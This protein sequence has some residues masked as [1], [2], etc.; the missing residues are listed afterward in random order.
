MIKTISTILFILIVSAGFAQ[1]A[2][3]FYNSGN[4]KFDKGQ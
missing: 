2:K 1:S 4:L 3:E